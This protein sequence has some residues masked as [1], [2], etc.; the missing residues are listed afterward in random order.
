MPKVTS[1]RIAAIKGNFEHADIITE[2]NLA[3]LIDAIAEAAE[4]HGHTAT[5]GD[6]TGTGDAGPVANLKSGT[7]AQK[8]ANPE[9]GD[10]YLETDTSKLYVCFSEGIWEEIVSG[11]ALPEVS[12]GDNLCVSSDGEK[13][14]TNTEYVKAK[15]IRVYRP[16]TYRIKFDLVIYGQDLTAYGRIYRNGSPVGTE[17]SNATITWVTFSEDIAGWEQGDLIQLYY[18]QVGGTGSE[19]ALVRNFRIYYDQGPLDGYVTLS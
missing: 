5:G 12:A 17:R 8:P 9:V 4:A 16:G 7:Q 2:D 15:E 3:D 11:P 19:A 13:G 10:V 6:G 18:R 14:T 1:E